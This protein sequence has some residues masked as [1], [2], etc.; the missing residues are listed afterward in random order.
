MGGPGGAPIEFKLTGLLYEG[1]TLIASYLDRAT[2]EVND[3]QF[4]ILD[5]YSIIPERDLPNTLLSLNYRGILSSELTLDVIYAEKE[6]TFENSGGTSRDPI[7]G[8][9]I[10]ASDQANL[11]IGAPFFSSEPPEERDNRTMSAK[12]S[13]FLSTDSMGSHDI[14][15]GISDFQ[16]SLRSD[17]HQS[18][19]D[20]RIFSSWTRWETPANPDAPDLYDTFPNAIPI[21]TADFASRMTYW[22][23]INSSQGSD[24]T[25]QSAYINDSWTLSD[26]W[27]FNLG[28]RYDRNDVKAQDGTLLSDDQ[29][30]S[31][32]LA[33][34]FD[35]FADGSHVLGLSYGKYVSRIA[36]VADGVS[37]SGVPATI[38]WYYYGP[39][40]ESLEEIFF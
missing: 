17:N 19:S 33:M 36:N 18:A 5:E 1:H 25:V 7:L 31:P 10:E 13:Y 28:L 15:V 27:R 38:G 35:P 39:T 37:S 21:F 29:A 14:V 24:F 6:F 30:F 32:R 3:V 16:E 12:L 40:S 8:S 9:S 26:R 11:N 4:G 22:P 23:I 20:W 2:T 34:F